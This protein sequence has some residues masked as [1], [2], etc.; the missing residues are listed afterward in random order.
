MDESSEGD[1][2]LD[3]SVG[4]E[5]FLATISQCST[6]PNLI[7]KDPVFFVIASCENETRSARID[8][9]EVAQNDVMILEKFLVDI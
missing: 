1:L 2:F 6:S 9:Y 5:P 3:G 7:F 4:C 8:S